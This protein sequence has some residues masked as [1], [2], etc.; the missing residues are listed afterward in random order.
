MSEDVTETQGTKI[1]KWIMIFI[2]GAVIIAGL[3]TIGG[4]SSSKPASSSQSESM[5]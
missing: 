3:S 5:F 2:I 4:E 1:M